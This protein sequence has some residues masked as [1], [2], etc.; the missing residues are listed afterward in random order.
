MRRTP[1]TTT[2]SRRQPVIKTV[3]YIR[4]SGDDDKDANLERAASVGSSEA[5]T[6]AR[7][8]VQPA[9]DG[10]VWFVDECHVLVGQ[11]EAMFAVQ[12]AQVGRGRV[13]DINVETYRCTAHRS[14]Q[15]SVVHAIDVKTFLRF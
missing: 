11:N 3:I 13:V 9:E 6:V 2:P 8:P 15:Y 10:A 1:L 12:V 14:T 4:L 7:A 5:V